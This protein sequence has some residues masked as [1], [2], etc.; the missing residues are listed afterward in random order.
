MKRRPCRVVLR[1]ARV[2][3][4]DYKI[5]SIP[6]QAGA[7]QDIVDSRFQFVPMGLKPILVVPNEQVVLF[8]MEE[9]AG[10]ALPGA[11]PGGY[12]VQQLSLPVLFGNDIFGG[13]VSR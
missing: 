8:Q 1:L 11:E 9:A 5:P 10:Y 3:R 4:L 2:A 13:Q 12:R 6:V 7:V